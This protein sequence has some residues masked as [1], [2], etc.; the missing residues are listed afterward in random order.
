MKKRILAMLM[1]L[2]L[3]AACVPTP[4]EDYIVN[5]AEEQ[6]PSETDGLAEK[7]VPISVPDHATL[8][9]DPTEHVTVVVD[10]EVNFNAESAHPILEVEALNITQDEET[11]NALLELIA[12]GAAMY[13]GW[14][15]TKEEIAELLQSAMRYDGQLGSLVLPKD[16]MITLLEMQ[17]NAAPEAIDK[18]PADKPEAGKSYRMERSDG[19]ISVLTVSTEP[20]GFFYQRDRRDACFADDVLM[21]DDP[22]VL[23]DPEISETD[24]RRKAEEFLKSLGVE[25]DCFVGTKRGFSIRNYELHEMLWEFEFVRSVNGTPSIRRPNSF[26]TDSNMP[27]SI[28]AP[29]FVE[30]AWVYVGKDGVVSANF[31][32]LSRVKRV[33]VKDVQLCDFNKALDTGVRQIGYL[34]DG[35][36]DKSHHTYMVTNIDL[37]YGLQAEEDNLSVGVYQPM[38]EF[39]YADAEELDEQPNKI[40]ISA[41]TGGYVEPRVTVQALM[42]RAE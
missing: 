6:L 35:A 34:H 20:N 19:V 5:R 9:V 40:Y 11:L 39:T 15:D 1:L 24:A 25:C 38:W 36:M 28:G 31:D 17:Y 10:A 16:E 33:A 22:I 2:C 30:N 8:N 41:I 14:P 42:K 4:E 3:L 12:P 29:W 18:T 13:E 7:T 21:P 26:M 27:S 32:G 23:T 37:C